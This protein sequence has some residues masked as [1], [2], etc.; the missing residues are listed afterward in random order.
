MRYCFWIILFLYSFSVFAEQE[1]EVYQEEGRYGM[2]DPSGEIIIPAVYEAI[3]WS[4]GN[5]RQFDNVVGY[6]EKGQWGIISLKNKLITGPEYYSLIVLND[7]LLGSRKGKFSNQLLYG[8]LNTK[9]QGIVSFRYQ[10]IRSWKDGNYVV[11][12]WVDGLLKAGII[13]STGETIVPIRYKDL[14]IDHRNYVRVHTFGVYF[15]LYD[16][17]GIL[18][19][20]ES[21]EKLEIKGDKIE[22]SLSGQLG[23]YDFSGKQ[24]LEPRYKSIDGET[25]KEFPKWE[26]RNGL[27]NILQTFYADSIRALGN[28]NFL[29]F[30]NGHKTIYQKDFTE[31]P[32]LAEKEIIAVSDRYILLHGPD[33]YE[34]YR[35]TGSR[36]LPESYDS[37]IFDDEFIYVKEFDKKDAWTIYNKFGTKISARRYS[38]VRPHQEKIIPV[39]L[40][41]YWGYIDENGSPVVNCKFDSVGDFY[42]GRGIV[43]FLDTWGLIGKNGDWKILP[44][45]NSLKRVFDSTYMSQKERHIKLFDHSGKLMN[46]ITERIRIKDFGILVEEDSIHFGLLGKSGERLTSIAYNNIKRIPATELVEVEI[47]GARGVIWENGRLVLPMDTLN[48]AVLGASEGYIGIKRDGKFGF[49]DY[50]GRL[51]ISNR[52]DSA[53]LFSNSMAAIKINGNWGYID[54]HENLVIQPIYDDVMPFA[55]GTTAVSYQTKWGLINDA[56][57]VIQ[58][59]QFDHV[60]RTSYNSYVI[61]VNG[62]TGLATKEGN[63]V[64]FPRYD[65]VRDLGNGNVIISSGGKWGVIST[66]GAYVIPNLYDQLIYDDENNLYFTRKGA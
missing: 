56:G 48:N 42:L 16:P 9:G 1:Y 52:Y 41:G 15:G 26:V 25:G 13:S 46:S 7:F 37:A 31:N 43:K 30:R 18:V 22:V 64:V 34:V 11:R 45:E 33:K 65:Y 54:K 3:G 62:K 60:E 8:V 28:E 40:A 51:R 4:D 36:L 63:V 66:K 50:E 55:S 27:N 32:Q 53:A 61:K 49:V 47:Q 17:N 12:E 57:V 19:V 38:S 14:Q 44:Y 6:K 10:S 21:F 29:L 20:P 35:K 5:Q 59:Y 24:L 39:K 23:L 58:N 2:K